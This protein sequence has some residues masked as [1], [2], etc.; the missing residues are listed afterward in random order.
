MLSVRWWISHF[1][2]G[3]CYFT[4]FHLKHW[5]IRH[6]WLCSIMF[7]KITYF[8]QV[9]RSKKE[10]VFQQPFCL[11]LPQWWGGL[12]CGDTHSWP[13][14]GRA[15]PVESQWSFPISA[16][17]TDDPLIVNTGLE[18]LNNA[19]SW[20]RWSLWVSFSF[21]AIGQDA[22]SKL[23][24]SPDLLLASIFR[25]SQCLCIR[26]QKSFSTTPDPFAPLANGRLNAATNKH[27]ACF[28]SELN[29]SSC[30]SFH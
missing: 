9:H 20:L 4:M 13:W 21:G 15:P 29:K 12:P 22:L 10:T 16:Q 2:P 8:S 19:V 5:F 25:D 26:L 11:P 7:H 27:L 1:K 28:C 30:R 24:P 18:I 14:H 17:L 6:L 3:G 23:L